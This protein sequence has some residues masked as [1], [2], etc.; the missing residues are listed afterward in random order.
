[1]HA[2]PLS[3]H[4]FITAVAFIPFLYLAGVLAVAFL[5]LVSAL[6]FIRL[7][8][9]GLLGWYHQGKASLAMRMLSARTCE[10]DAL[11]RMR[12]E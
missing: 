8:R 6:R 2:F 7:C 4:A 3:L 1:M 10:C 11:M 12:A 9:G 5:S